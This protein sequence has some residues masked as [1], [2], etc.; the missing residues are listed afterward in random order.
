[1][2][3][4]GE[5]TKGIYTG[6]GHPIVQVG[7]FKTA[8]I[9]NPL[10][11][12]IVLG[13]LT[14]AGAY[15]PPAEPKGGAP[16]IDSTG[17]E[18]RLSFEPNVLVVGAEGYPT[19]TSALDAARPFDIVK[20]GAGLI[21]ENVV[22]KKPVTL[23]GMGPQT[24]YTSTLVVSANDVTLSGHTFQNIY[25]NSTANVWDAGGIVT[26]QTTGTT[27][28]NGLVSRLTVSSC[29]FTNCRQGVFLFGAKSST[30]QD[31]TFSGCYRGITV[32]GHYIGTALT[33]TSSG[34]T[35][36]NCKFYDMVGS[37]TEDGE[38]I[39]INAS[40]SNTVD[41]CE[42][43]G[44]A[45][46]VYIVTGTGNV[47]QR[48]TISDSTYEPVFAKGITG[49]L[50][51]SSN[52]IRGNARNV[53]FESCS[54]FSFTSNTL[55]DNDAGPV[56]VSGSA[57]TF[58]SNTI[59][60]NAGDVEF[61]SCSGFTCQGNTINGSSVM[62][63]TSTTGT[64]ASNTFE[65]SGAPT[66]TFD[67]G[68]TS[69]YGHAIATSNT[70]NG[71]AIYYVYSAVDR[72]VDEVDAGAIILAACTRPVVTDSKVT[73][74]DGIR[75]LSSNGYSIEAKV[76]NCLFGIQVMSSNNGHIEG[77]DVTGG[78]R[79]TNA[80]QIVNCAGTVVG[81]TTLSA[82]GTAWD[83]R[84]EMH[85]TVNGYNVSFDGDRVNA[86]SNSGGRLNVWNY[87]DV[88]VLDNG[89]VSPLPGV[90]VDVTQDGTT[91]CYRT[92]H[93]G[94]TDDVTDASGKLAPIALLDRVYDYANAATE[95]VHRITVW[96]SID[97]VWTETRGGLDMSGPRSEVFEA[98]DIRA[99]GTPLNLVVVDQPATDSMA[100]SWDPNTDD[101]V[102]YSLYWDA[103][104]TWT[105]LHNLSTPIVS[106]TLSSGLVHG[107]SYNF[108]VS[109]WDEVPLQSPLT[110]IMSVLHVDGLAPVAPEGLRAL[111]IN[112]TNCTVG[113]DASTET[114]LVGY[115][116]YINSTGAG[117][118][119]PWTRLTPDGGTPALE[120]WVTGLL[121]E[122]DHYFMLTAFD[123]VPNESPASLVLEVRTLDI[124]PP[125]APELDALP[126]FTNE[127]A[128]TVE[129]RA[130]PGST[131]TVFIGTDEV[132]T[133]V[134]AANGALSIT[135][136][137]VEGLNVVTARAT[138]GSGNTG[139]LSIPVQTVLDTGA[140][141]APV[142]GALP[143]LTNV[144]VHTLA[145]TAEGLSTVTVLLNGAVAGTIVTAEDGAFALELTL[146]EGENL[147]TAFA[148]DRAANPGPRATVLRVV[149]D[150]I[151]PEPP[152]VTA[153]PAYVNAAALTLS[154]TAEPR[155]KVEVMAAGEVLATATAD[156]S[157]AFTA[158]LTLTD[159]E[160]LLLARAT[161]E[162]LNTGRPCEPLGVILDAVPPVAIAGTD[163]SR[164]EETEITFDG[165]ASTDNEGIAS[166][167]WN[168][169][170]GVE[171]KVLTG[172]K[173]MF[174]FDDPV[175]LTVTLTVRDLAGNTQTDTVLVEIVKKNLPPV[176][177]LGAMGPDKG[178]TK[179]E[180]EFSVT[181]TDLDGDAGTV[182]VFIDGVQYT[183]TA[184]PAD[185]NTR[186]G[187]K[188]T[189]KTKLATGP[190]TYY[191]E[192]QDDQGNA[193]GGSSA[194]PGNSMTSQEVT[195]AKVKSPGATVPL[196]VT[197]LA[198]VAALAASG[199]HRRRRDL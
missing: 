63:R 187:R 141:A 156:A 50:T 57:F 180:F 48:C 4:A 15:L 74:G 3:R 91:A 51:V 77:C 143:A 130:E 169:R 38:A 27:P 184:D 26:R 161:D 179:T 8:R 136:T 124:T 95:H 142:L 120:L 122:T 114:D 125:T 37:A 171:D 144:T 78:S 167:T 89:T 35:I 17:I 119:G 87:L 152:V 146:R 69:H 62:L 98:A 97:A 168:F 113:W 155:S 94:G 83:W 188:Y 118:T 194:G 154:G 132:A 29:T 105:L 172:D 106:Y 32:R 76:S 16:S 115:H 45:Y 166:H 53:R 42:M 131:V 135:I 157:G 55:T 47:V 158:S 163:I 183:L 67:I 7:V 110:A 147:M 11:V 138:D 145:G 81:N 189:Y 162:A 199:R 181:Y 99:P 20:V 1:M 165:S 149:L 111:A 5:G 22:I 88:K 12:L 73:D 192:G 153:P 24:V 176:L 28:D 41:G 72:V 90:E 148:T 182:I 80:I 54:G 129:G 123:E 104:G 159:R 9:L 44:N 164:V 70:V 121:S 40:N 52:A 175:T 190:H 186:D 59:R 65:L 151:A 2:D 49:S 61:A 170:L 195:K 68:T 6:I 116:L 133:G 137:L 84:L 191:F 197:A 31:C 196:T 117:Q 174:T 13:L 71:R 134:A 34:N 86:S 108:R 102:V 66:F 101:T 112:G 128:R 39:A 75:V 178:T 198:A 10:V 18:D 25:D 36:K 85:S 93:F 64:F 177:T 92:P 23:L 185:T 30:V 82:Q 33:W 60:G 150:T 140:P 127:S 46:G 58:N 43:D 14:T 103:T 79:G 193:A 109:A 56:V 173:P 160:T 19:I 139:P 107:V 21:T 96:A 100:V 126:R